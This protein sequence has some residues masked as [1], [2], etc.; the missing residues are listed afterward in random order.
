MNDILLTPHFKL[1]EFIKSPTASAIGI[2]NSLDSTS[3]PQAE[4]IIANLKNLSEQVL[5]PLR[6]HFGVPII[7]GSGYRCPALN[8][9]VGGVPNSQH[10]TGEA[11]DIHIPDVATGNRWFTWMMENLRFDQLIKERA[12]KA[13]KSFW[14]HVSLKAND[15]QRQHVIYNL[16]KNPN[17]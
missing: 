7:I 11:V 3:S 17:A 5:E 4:Q 2:D 8:K 16:I 15:Q 10:Q 6:Q 13:S 12:T 9:A 1:S 14:I